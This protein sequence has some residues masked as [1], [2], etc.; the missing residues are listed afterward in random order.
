V[1]PRA[2]ISPWADAQECQLLNIQYLCTA[3]EH[4]IF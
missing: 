4:T 1:V 2:E 3:C